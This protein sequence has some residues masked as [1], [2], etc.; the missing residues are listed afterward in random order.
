MFFCE[1]K[2][3]CHFWQVFWMLIFLINIYYIIFLILE[4]GQYFKLKFKKD[5]KL[6]IT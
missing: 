2:L 3:I 5:L 4:M 6:S 1:V